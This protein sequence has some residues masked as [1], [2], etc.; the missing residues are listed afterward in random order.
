MKYIKTFESFKFDKSDKVDE[1][2]LGEMLGK[3]KNKLSMSI[4]N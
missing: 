4:S 1:G 2:F 3:L